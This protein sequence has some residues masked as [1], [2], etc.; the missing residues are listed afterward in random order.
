[1]AEY[2]VQGESITAVAD[3]IR[4]KGGTTAPLS[5]PAGMAKA[6]RGIPS[7]GTDISLGLT[8]ATV[9]QTIKVK[10]VDASGKPTAWEAVDA[11]GVETW[12]KIAEIVIPE[13]A[14][15]ST[16]LTINKDS[17]GNPFSLVKARLCAKFPKYTGATTI[18]NFS[19]AMLN[20]KTSGRVPPLA[21][22]SAWPKVSTSIVTG[23]VYEVDVSGTQQIEHVRKSGSGG[24]SDDSARDYI[25]YGSLYDATATWFANTLWA[26]PITS[27]GGA[28]MVIYPGCR[29]VLYGVRA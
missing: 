20:G 8:A 16:V 2:L 29:F 13:G 18:P 6:V 4:E 27:I 23:T 24:W 5:F 19:F 12:E 17:D 11:A 9:G 15:E 3:A 1:M 10:A 14:D 25:L 26:K 28:G 7:G 22:T 21:Y